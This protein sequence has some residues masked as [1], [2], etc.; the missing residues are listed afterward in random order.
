MGDI[1]TL[2]D[3]FSDRLLKWDLQTRLVAGFLIATCVT[4]FVATWVGIWTINK[5]MLAEIQNRVR[6]DMK[7]ARL[8]FDSR[9]DNIKYLLIMSA[10]ESALAEAVQRRDLR[11]NERLRNLIQ[12]V[13]AY[14]KVD[15]LVNMLSVTDAEGNVLYRPTNP[16]SL[17]D[18]VLWD[19][20]IRKCIETKTPQ[21]STELM[22]VE[23][24]VQ[25]NPSLRERLMI[26]V[27]KTP[28][29]YDH[30]EKRLSKGMVIRVACPILTS[31][32]KMVGVLVGGF[33]LNND[34]TI[35]DKVKETIYRDEKYKG[36]EMGVVTIFQGGVR[37]STNV[38]N[39]ENRRAIGTTLSDEVYRQ[40]V[41]EGKEWVGRAFV[42]NDWYITTYTPIHNLEN[43]VV[44]IIYTGILEEKYR[45]VKWRA[46]AIS[47]G[48]IFFGMI[49]AFIISFR[50]G[51]TIIRRIRLLKNATEAV[52]AGDLDYKLSPDKISGFDILDEAFNNM[53]RSLKDR[54]ERLQKVHEQLAR[55][56][57][58]TALGEMAAGVAHEINNPLGGIL[59]YSNLVLEDIP[60]DSPARENM[61]KII[62]QTNRCKEIVQKLL[63]FS[64]APTGEMVPTQI[65]DVIEASI[66]FVKDQA[67]FNGIEID[68]R[69]ADDLPDV[70]GDRS[71]LEQVFLNLFINAADAMKEH[72]G[73][74]T[75]VTQHEKP[76]TDLRCMEDKEGRR[77]TL[78]TFAEEE[79]MVQVTISDTGKGIDKE[80]LPHIFEPFFTT[81]EP[82]QGTGLGLSIVYGV[83]RK[84]NGY[85]EAESVSGKGTTFA[86]TLPSCQAEVREKNRMI[87][88]HVDYEGKERALP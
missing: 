79:P 68:A 81:K 60:S 72:K 76:R 23:R 33:L 32:E 45:D 61:G 40:V 80:Y 22:P 41:L 62:Y 12:R 48:V 16:G 6:Q 26:D 88:E 2:I 36:R 44:G 78:A 5:I 57:K 21:A 83:I 67:M 19:P 84:H 82:G 10:E 71:L 59:L 51:S 49:V 24:I 64:R 74:L 27:I 73:K 30:N 63:D 86:I 37:I 58:L 39:S 11:R 29:S 75:I 47:L 1:V 15:R 20:V 25:E 65:N 46:I 34:R 28:K 85:I 38:M 8:I 70:M 52:A 77:F 43:K 31:G 13:P 87:G 7:T 14:R 9:L 53:S 50:L 35:V 17:G 54:D 55:S 56:E 69:L 3:R 66:E 4:G 18:N 42:V